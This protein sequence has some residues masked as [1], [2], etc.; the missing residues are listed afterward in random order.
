MTTE[1]ET[2]ALIEEVASAYRERDAHGVIQSSPAFHDLDAGQRLHAF[3]VAVRARALE[4][5]LDPANL[6]T[7]ARAILARIR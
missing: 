3:D 4:A 1:A 5:A 6:S 7:T 2:A